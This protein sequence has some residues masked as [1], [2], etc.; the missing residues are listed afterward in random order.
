MSSIFL[1][2]SLSYLCWFW[3]TGSANPTWNEIV[4]NQW[5]TRSIA[6]VSIAIQTA[7]SAQAAVAT[8]MLAILFLEVQGVR[9][10]DAAE[11]SILRYSNS[12]PL[13]NIFVFLRNCHGVGAMFQLSLL[14][15]LALITAALQFTSTI[16]LTDVRGSSLLDAETVHNRTIGL[17]SVGLLTDVNSMSTRPTIFANFF[18]IHR[19]S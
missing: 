16:L 18:G 13:L 14:V 5:T 8:S 7:T 1:V 10:R 11:F 2:A 12:G 9:L 4:K 6:T 15:L 3:N 17:I 19:A